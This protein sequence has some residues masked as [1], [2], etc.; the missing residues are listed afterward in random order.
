MTKEQR[1]E[2]YAAMVAQG[3]RLFE[4]GDRAGRNLVA[5]IGC[6][7]ACPTQGGRLPEGWHSRPLAAAWR[8]QAEHVETHCPRCV[9]EWGWGDGL[10]DPNWKPH[11]N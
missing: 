4:D 9:K 11:G 7:L 10:C 8:F 5:C 1:I 3:H 2:H 6:G